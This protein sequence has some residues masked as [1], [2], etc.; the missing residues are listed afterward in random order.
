ML[1]KSCCGFISGLTL[2]VAQSAMAQSVTLPAGR[3]QGV[4]QGDVSSF[5]GIPFAAPPV[6][7]NRWRAPQP[8]AP[9]QG[10][11]DAGKF[12]P[13]CA[14]PS[15]PFGASGNP[16]GTSEDC[17]TLNIWRPARVKAGQKLPVMV[18]I[19]GGGFVVGSGAQPG[20]DGSQFARQG[21]ILVTFNYRLGRFGFFAHPAL[22]A[23]HPD[24]PKGNFAL[25]DQIEALRWVRKNI[26]ALGGDPR[27]VT[28][29][30][31]SA[32]GVSV[33]NLLTSPMAKGLFHKAIIQSGG[34]RDGT[35]TARPLAKDNT[36][37]N[38]QISAETIGRNFATRYGIAGEG[39]AA[40][41]QLRALSPDQ[42]ID[43]GQE[44]AGAN[45]PRTYS[46]PIMDG[47]VIV[48]TAQT[49]YLHGRQAK[50]PLMIGSNS[51]EVPAGFVA[52]ATKQSLFDSFGKGK[53]E[54]IA[55]Y[56]PDGSADLALLSAQINTDRVWAEP[57]RLTA[58]AF[59]EAGSTAFV[60]R[61][62]YVADSMKDRFKLG[63]PHASEIDYV[64]DNVKA[65]YGAALTAQD[66]SVAR[67][68]NRYW[69]NFA[70]TGRPDGPGLPNWPRFTIAGQEIMDIQADGKAVG[71]PNATR[72][73]LDA[74]ELADGQVIPR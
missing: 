35:L 48:E 2:L 36:D 61:F 12:G 13:D 22:S 74:N 73:R 45:G 46:G 54:A 8:I 28:I 10:V 4:T 27:N 47:R 23:E 60:Y 43:G 17:L 55:A 16:A 31:E 50:V 32:G 21:V 67:L 68:M 20:Y 49:A 42:V 58:R 69:A 18:W 33:H 51:A 5:K 7:P 59:T 53:P 1:V 37:P 11:L 63:A 24:E 72:A 9:W 41:A 39:A 40:L 44:T 26:A 6:G 25:L 71:G 62:G 30:G 57:A 70:K 38:Y 14:Q 34:G 19:Y 29:F 66:Q 56:D 65:R 3:L 52:G 64:F 15:S